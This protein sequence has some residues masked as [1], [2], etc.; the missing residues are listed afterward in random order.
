M[1]NQKT[2]T[3]LQIPD[4]ELDPWEKTDANGGNG[5]LDGQGNA[6]ESYTPQGEEVGSTDV[7]LADGFT[8]DELNSSDISED[9]WVIKYP[10]SKY[11]LR[12]RD[13]EARNKR[14]QFLQI[15]A[16]TGSTK[17]AAA[18]VNLTPRALL[19][20]RNRIPDFAH[21]WDMATEIY[22][23]FV[24]DEKIRQRAVDGVKT[25]IWYQGDIVGYE[26]KYDSGLTQFW[27][28]AN[29]RDKYGDKSE[30]KVTGGITHGVALLPSTMVNLGDWEKQASK[31]HDEHKIIDITPTIVDTKEDK[32]RVGGP[33]IE[34]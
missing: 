4:S 21:N 6:D 19:L 5:S 32:V 18:Q 33:K 1:T 28:R 23:E 30:I 8:D 2:L 24:A 26:I 12:P 34:R 31:V 22:R 29:M 15:L 27:A 7:A 20:A 9:E 17:K 13:I 10:P 3:N 14:K 11:P 25:A 16:Q